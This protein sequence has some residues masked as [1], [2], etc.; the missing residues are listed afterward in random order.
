MS[1]ASPRS[2][3]ARRRAAGF[4]FIE[5]TLVLAM[6]A[7]LAWL[8]ERTFVTTSDAD[9][10]VRATQHA[11]DK[12][13]RLA[14]KLRELV[15]ASRRLFGR[16]ATGEAYRQALEVVRVPPAPDVRLPIIDPTGDLAP[17]A[18]DAKLTGNSLLFV[19]ESDP[20][21]VVVDPLLGTVRYIDTYRFIYVYP[22]DTDV[23]LVTKPPLT[24]ARD[25]VV[26][27]SETY[28]NYAQIIGLPTAAQRQ[29][30]VKELTARYGYQYAWDPS[31]PVTDSFFAMDALGA[32]SAVAE[33]DFTI[34]EDMNVSNVG[35]LVY[36][37]LQ[38][39]PSDITRE[40]YDRRAW[41]STDNDWWPH[42]F[43]TK[44]V[45]SSGSRKV[46]MRLTVEARSVGSGS[47][48][49]ASQLI[50]SAHDL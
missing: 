39:A 19:R 26:W 29:E 5:V 38:L 33:T 45:G 12:G 28:P 10:H 2:G 14:Y 34:L 31:G 18:T 3:K 9:Q 6:T 30:A 1:T 50:A 35:T 15:S 37:G 41:L 13:Q 22:A 23:I 44:I 17:D 43:E 16:D 20:A 4:T 27:R 42:G 7:L 47:V 32:I 48:V 36:A 11:T 8:V 46:W 49:H 21:E 24:A 25:I 40:H